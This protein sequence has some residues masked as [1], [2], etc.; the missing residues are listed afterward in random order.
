MFPVCDIVQ[1][2]GERFMSH[3]FENSQTVPVFHIFGGHPKV[4]RLLRTK[5]GDGR[6]DSQNPY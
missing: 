6:T 4:I 1:L 5:F 3:A 2:V